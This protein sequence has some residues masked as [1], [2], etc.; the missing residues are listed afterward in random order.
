VGE[1][2]ET[3]E[4]GAVVPKTNTPNCSQCCT[5]N[6]VMCAACSTNVNDAPFGFMC[7]I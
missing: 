1:E 5:P 2:V 7:Q 4:N 6:A 3:A